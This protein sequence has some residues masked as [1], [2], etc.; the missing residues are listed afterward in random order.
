MKAAKTATQLGDEQL[1]QA[2]T[3][4]IVFLYDGRSGKLGLP[5]DVTGFEE[6]QAHVWIG[7][8]T[9][10]VQ[11]YEIVFREGMPPDTSVNFSKFNELVVPA[12][13][14]PSVI[15]DSSSP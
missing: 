12:I 7:K 5:A 13:K 3:T 14:E 9:F 10:Y 2:E 15:T 1:D 8:N 11:Q 4:H 6:T